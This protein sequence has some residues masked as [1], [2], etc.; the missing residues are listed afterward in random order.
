MISPYWNILTVVL[1][2]VASSIYIRSMM[3]GKTIPNKMGWFIWML[4][5]LASSFI[6]LQNGGGWSAIPVFMSWIIPLLIFSVSFFVKD[7]YWKISKLDIFCLI[8]ALIAIYFWLVAK[9]IVSA[10]I[11][12]IIADGFGF[13]PTI[14]KSW[15]IPETENPYPY[16]AGFLNAS[17]GLLSLTQYEFYLYGMPLYLLFGNS[18]LLL[19]IM[20]KKFFK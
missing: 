2:L 3:Q 10:T 12:A 15:V 17:I 7:S 19:V 18:I 4:A 6:I 11:F 20:R 8:S 14:V 13:V 1:S 16:M 5:P 9:D